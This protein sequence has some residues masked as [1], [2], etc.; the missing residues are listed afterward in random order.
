MQILLL[1]LIKY[2]VGWT[3][4]TRFMGMTLSTR[5]SWL[6]ITSL[7]VK[8]TTLCNV[9]YHYSK[10]KL[11]NLEIPSIS[12]VTGYRLGYRSGLLLII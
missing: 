12:G 11:H 6:C 9:V 1:Q 3:V 4:I 2:V 10:Y 8:V 7:N 5:V